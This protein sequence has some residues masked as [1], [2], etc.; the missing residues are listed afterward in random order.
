ML[1]RLVGTFALG[2]ALAACVAP[3]APTPVRVS[4]PAA[5]PAP[6]ASGAQFEDAPMPNRAAK[7]PTG[8]AII[9]VQK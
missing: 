9:R 8:D 4:R 2:M 6:V 3:E 7:A 1:A 5:S